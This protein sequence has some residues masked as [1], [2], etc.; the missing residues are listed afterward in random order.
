MVVQFKINELITVKLENEK[1]VIYVANDRS[2]HCKYLLL[3][4]PIKD[5]SSFDEIESIDEAA[6]LLDR[7]L[8]FEGVDEEDGDEQEE[9]TTRRLIPP[10]V[11]FWAHCSN[12]QVWAENEY[13]SQLLHSNLAFPLLRKLYFSN[14]PIAKKVFKKEIAKRLESGFPPVVEFLVLQKYLDYLNDDEFSSVIQNPKVIDAL[15]RTGYKNE[16][17]QYQYDGLYALIR[18]IKKDKNSYL[19]TLIGELLKTNN[20]ELLY[21]LDRTTIMYELNKTE[22]AYELLNKEEAIAIVELLSIIPKEMDLVI[23]PIVKNSTIFIEDKHVVRLNLDFCKL[24]KIPDQLFKFK[25]LE[26]L[27]LKGNL[28]KSL[29]DTIEAFGEMKYLGLSKNKISTIS[30]K[31][32][33]LKGLQNLN[34][35]SNLIERLPNTIGELKNLRIL[36]ISKNPLRTIPKSLN[37]LSDLNII[38]E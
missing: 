6:E 13:N 21:F 15:V 10:R 26:G 4:I 36:N 2:W 33:E 34:L 1:T 16:E 30:E 11:E 23:D 32:G 7:R 37:E 5:V 27:Y 28:L 17:D 29:P 38:K 8:D 31:I 9:S 19:K 22:L 20:K 25:K 14:D 24:K 12:L 18:K 3:S 35:S